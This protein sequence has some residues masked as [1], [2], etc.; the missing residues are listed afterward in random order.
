MSTMRVK[1]TLDSRDY[2]RGVKQM[3]KQ[4]K[5]FSGGLG[6]IGKKMKA[7]FAIAAILA[8]VRGIARAAKSLVDFGSKISDL[9]AQTGVGVER[10]EQ[11]NDAALNAGSSSEKMAKALV[12]LKDAQGE[13]LDGDKLMTDAFANLGLS[14]DEVAGMETD[15]LFIAVSKALTESGN[16]AKELSATFDILGKRNAMELTEAM[17]EVAGGIDNVNSAGKSLSEEQAQRLDV[18]ADKWERTKKSIMSSA[19]G[20][21]AGMF[22][23]N[24]SV[25]AEVQERIASTARR[26]TREAES[27]AFNLAKLKNEEEA[28]RLATVDKVRIAEEKIA[29]ERGK[30]IQKIRES[31]TIDIQTN[32]LRRIGG[33]AGSKVSDALTQARKQTEIMARIEDYNSSLPQIEKN[34]ENQ[35]LA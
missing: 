29:A 11:F 20:I 35:G 21:L 19:A 14:I 24:E 3:Q 2:K 10:L 16:G 12:S 5:G 7:A 23:A 30:A 8:V 22:G 28:K 31:V 15:Q 34:T 13:V 18:I 6:K 4:N 9:S 33:F 25:D 27:R 26:K 32:S 1:S 17:N